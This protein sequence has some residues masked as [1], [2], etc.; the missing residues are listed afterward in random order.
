MGNH[1]YE[2]VLLMVLYSVMVHADLDPV[3]KLK[4]DFEELKSTLTALKSDLDELKSEND[5]LKCKNAK[6]F[7]KMTAIVDEMASKNSELTK[8]LSLLKNAPFYHLCVYQRS[9]SAKSSVM[10]FE[11]QLYMECN[12]CDDADFNLNTGVYTNGWPGTYTV[13][14]NSWV[15][16]YHGTNG[17]RIYLRK[18]GQIINEAIQHSYFSRDNGG[19]MEEQ[20]GRTMLIRMDA[21]NILDLFCYDCSNGVYDIT[22]TISLF[23]FDVV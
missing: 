9:T 5:E 17:A 16:A 18:N 13:S 8:E 6:D 19:Y 23:T 4:E 3:V 1:E 7:E 11:K 14:W 22:F 12:L 20:G 10:T 21:G 2:D 15:M